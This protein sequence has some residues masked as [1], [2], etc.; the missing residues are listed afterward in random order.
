M[1]DN[2]KEYDEGQL[3]NPVDDHD[4]SIEDNDAY[5]INLS[6]VTYYEPEKNLRIAIV[7][8]IVILLFCVGVY[9]YVKTWIGIS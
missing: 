1:K 7:G 6:E 8:G 5:E 3:Y 4:E 9:I 2:M